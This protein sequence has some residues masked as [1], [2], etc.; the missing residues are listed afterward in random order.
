MTDRP[1][2]DVESLRAALAGDLVSPGDTGWD[3]ARRAWN[4]V[5]DQRPA[6]VVLAATPE[7]VTATVRFAAANDLRVA[8]QTT[9]HGA[10][11][12]GDL[13]DAILLRT[14]R[15]NG[16]TVDPGSRTAQ[17]QAGACWRDV[18]AAA[19]T[20]GLV[21]LH[22]FSPTVGVAGYTLAGGIGWLA[23]RD[24]LA[25][26]HVRSFDVVTAVGSELLVD[27]RREPDLFWALRGGGGGP[28]VVTSLELELFPLA[29]AF[30]GALLWP[31]EQAS[32]VVHG[33]REWISTAPETVTSTVRLIRFPPLPELPD[34]LRGRALV[35]ITLAFAGS[36]AEGRD[37]VDP[38]RAIAPP[39]LDTLAMLPATAL[40]ELSGDPPGPLPGIGLG[41][42]VDSFSDEVAA[43]FVELAG[44]GVDSPLG[45]LEIRHLGGAL[46]TPTADPG[47][48]GAIMPEILVYGVGAPIAPEGGRAIE[49]ALAEVEERLAPWIATPRTLPTFDERGLGLRALFP[50]SVADR[51][52]AVA[53][54]YDPAGLFVANQRVE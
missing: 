39:Y 51:L 14:A 5:V 3:G 37:L 15:L 16:V 29:E 9:G 41:V 46:R 12:L 27:A 54:T 53:T 42:L 11:S 8:P 19:G 30:A 40:G 28:V 43:A 26:T 24:G 25:S 45:M 21:A 10:T 6:L 35:S 52:A 18:V 20:H 4:L 32:E 36:E 7:D 34:P 17:V 49:R 23:R 44:P 48:A 31:I 22:G 13:T 50:A 1:A 38:L 33:Y 47:A 2:I